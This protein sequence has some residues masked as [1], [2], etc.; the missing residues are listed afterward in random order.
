[1]TAS[2][3]QHA[4]DTFQVSTDPARLDLDAIHAYLTASYWAEGIPRELVARSLDGSLAFGLYDAERQIGLARV[5]TDRATFAYLCDVYVLEEYR[6][7]KLGVWLMECVVAHPDLQG[8]RRV[9]LAT[10][11]AHAFYARFGFTPPARPQA[12][13][14]IMKPGLYLKPP[15]P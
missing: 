7:L 9:I 5:I 2:V 14:E 1:M 6:G 8:L 15:A 11:D 10:R 12:L 4:R 3:F 13:M